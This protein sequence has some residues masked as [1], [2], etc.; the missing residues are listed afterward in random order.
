MSETTPPDPKPANKIPRQLY[1]NHPYHP[2]SAY[3]TPY[4]GG[5]PATAGS[6]EFNLARL[7]RVAKRRWLTILLVAIFGTLAA[8]YKLIMTTKLFEASSL[9][10]LRVRRPRIMNRDDAILS[11]VS[12]D[13]QS[14]R[15][16]NTRL[17]KFMSP[18][19]HLRVM[20][21]LKEQG[22]ADPMLVPS[23][24]FALLPDSH[25]VT[26]SCISPSPAEAA[27]AANAYAEEAVSVSIEENKAESES[28]VKWLYN[29]AAQQRKAVEAA[30]MAQVEF[31]RQH[32]ID[33]MESRKRTADQA[34]LD[35]SRQLI[36]IQSELEL[37]KK[38]LQAVEK[39]S[40]DLHELDKLPPDVPLS[41]E[42]RVKFEQWRTAVLEQEK[43]QM[44]YRGN[45]PNVASAA[46]V[47]Q[48]LHEAVLDL[49]NQSREA[50]RAK[51]S[52]LEQQALGLQAKAEEQRK[53]ATDLDIQLVETTAQLT[54]LDR[55]RQAEDVSFR[56]ILNR[57]EEARLSADENTA[58]VSLIERAMPPIIPFYP[59]TRRTLILGFL[60]GLAGGLGLAILKEILDD[61][62]TSTADV[63]SLAGVPVLGIV[64]HANLVNRKA[65]ACASLTRD[66]VHISE[67]FAGVRGVLVS[68]QH[69]DHTRSLL[70]T[71]TAPEDGKT[72]T[73]CNLA[74]IYGQSGTRTLLVDFDLRRPRIEG[75]FDVDP[76]APSLAHT[77]MNEAAGEAE[78]E[79]LI[80]PTACPNLSIISSRADRKL[81]A[82]KIMAGPVV[83]RF[84]DWARKRFDQIIIDAP[85]HGL[86][87]DA[88]ILAGQ[89]D[90]VVVVCR[91]DRTRR[92]ALRHTVHHFANLGTNVIGAIVNDVKIGKSS[93]FMEYAYYSHDYVHGEQSA[94][95]A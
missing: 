22:A 90:G 2:Y 60:L 86:V 95:K 54:A 78:F 50:I 82:A 28:A 70:V 59:N 84:I 51:I 37:A 21:R 31:R 76:S 88:S 35:F 71:S 34:V 4:Y 39:P 91:A 25:I 49:V 83:S 89:S 57:I 15:L 93:Y 80:Q 87:G 16:Y 53:L 45:H 64:P 79:T 33:L 1:H 29:Q 18:S 65:L 24:S 23:A 85:P 44:K 77:L 73:S 48:S 43:L 12:R 5:V 36:N 46:H 67:A 32:R 27:A 8:E 68:S 41:P 52:L 9:I 56:G 47:S 42:L 61:Q 92:R 72:I 14:D 55:G 38:L 13:W 74:L 75:I 94:P 26:V 10:E 7:F 69:A 40:V 30:D 62:I 20:N 81:N 17:Q 58:S 66:D 19:M 3:D 63:E 6:G 11:D